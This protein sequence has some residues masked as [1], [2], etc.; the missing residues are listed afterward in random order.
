MKNIREIQ[1]EEMRS[2]IN[3]LPTTEYRSH[4]FDLLGTSIRIYCIVDQLDVVVDIDFMDGQSMA[5]YQDLQVPAL[6]PWIQFV[7]RMNE[8][9]YLLW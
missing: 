6:F 9:G 7:R 2:I 8:A 5:F 4:S 1:E 3:S